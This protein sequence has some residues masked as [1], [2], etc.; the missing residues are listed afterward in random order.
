MHISHLANHND[1]SYY[2]LINKECNILI[3]SHADTREILCKPEITGYSFYR[4]LIIPTQNLLST[5]INGNNIHHLNILNIMRGG[6]N[7]P[8]E[9]SCANIGQY[10]EG[11]SFITTKRSF[12]E[13]EVGN[14]YVF[15]HKIALVANAT[16]IVGDIIASGNTIREVIQTIVDIYISHQLQIKKIILFTIGS[17]NMLNLIEEI[18]EKIKA[19]WSNFEGIVLLCYEGIFSTYT[20]KGITTLNTPQI[21]FILQDGFICPE[22]RESLLENPITIFEKC[23]IYDGGAR[24]FEP[25][26]HI[27]VLLNYWGSLCRLSST[28]DIFDFLKEKI[29]FYKGISFETWL[30]INHYTFIAKTQV[31]LLYKLYLSEQN[32]LQYLTSE[33]FVNLC[34]KRH[35]EICN[36]C[37]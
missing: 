35:D 12:N 4:K 2:Q 37:K 10:V 34:N 1:S 30:E 24:R 27:D 5:I 29:G 31:S 14:P 18:N 3:A 36:R 20:N 7:F 28:I 8:I 15:H 19:K 21:D 16:F 33:S 22:Y 6:L 9:E 26:E 11:T 17:L 13:N 32:L 23:T 25:M